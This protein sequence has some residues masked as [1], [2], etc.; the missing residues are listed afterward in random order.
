MNCVPKAYDPGT[1]QKTSGWPHAGKKYI[2]S[3]FTAKI[4]PKK[5]SLT[6][7]SPLALDGL[8]AP[9]AAKDLRAEP[10]GLPHSRNTETRARHSTR[11]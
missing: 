5:Y 9:C 11:I 2:F 1:K 8:A 7:P 4:A 6:Q 3:T 10:S